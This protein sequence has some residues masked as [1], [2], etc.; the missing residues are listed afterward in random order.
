MVTSLPCLLQQR[1][2]VKLFQFFRCCPRKVFISGGHVSRERR[3]FLIRNGF[4]L[5]WE[6]TAV[7]EPAEHF[8]SGEGSLKRFGFVKPR[9]QRKVV[10]SKAYLNFTQHE[11]NERWMD[12][13]TKHSRVCLQREKKRGPSVGGGIKG[14]AE[15]QSAADVKPRLLWDLRWSVWIPEDDSQVLFSHQL[16]H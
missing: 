1:L 14:F 3:S 4:F 8:R 11:Q 5:W 12:L 7:S 15:K 13:T 9:P 16:Q 2:V 6:N 10:L